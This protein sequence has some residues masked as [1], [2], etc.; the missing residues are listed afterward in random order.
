MV[1][2]QDLS[3]ELADHLLTS[4]FFGRLAC[5]APSQVLIVPVTY[6]YD[7][8]TSIYGEIQEGRLAQL[9]RQNPHVC[10]EVDKPDD[11]GCWYSVQIQGVFE[12]L[13]GDERLYVVQQLGPG[14][15]VADAEVADT[16]VTASSPVVVYRIRM[17]SKTGR[18]TRLR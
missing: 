12:E 6:W 3:P 9:L 16:T 2:V 11:L 15:T 17:L 14:R 8:H 4:Q 13:T 1:M 5:A 7:G 10:F 18:R